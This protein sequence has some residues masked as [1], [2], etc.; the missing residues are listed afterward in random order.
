MAH[1]EFI[2]DGAAYVGVSAQARGL[3]ELKT[4][5]PARYGTLSH[6]G[7]TF[8]YDMFTQVGQNVRD[9]F[10]KVLGGLEPQRMLATGESQSAGRLVTYLNAV[11]P[12]KGVF[13]GYMVHSRGAGGA[14]LS[15]APQPAVSVP[16][17]LKI[18]NDL[19]VPVFV[20]QAEGDV[21][22]SNLGAR[23]PD[24]PLFRS[25]ELAGTS[26]A[27]S[28]TAFAGFNDRG[29]AQGAI[30]MFNLMR[31]PLAIGCA[32]PI[33]AGPHHW[34][35]QAAFHHLDEWVRTGALPPSG[36]PL[37]V[38]STSPTVLA[39]DAHGNALGGVR[40]PHVDAPIATLDAVNSGAGFCV[41]FG[42]TTPFTTTQLQ[43]LYPTHDDFVAQ[44]YA[45]LIDAVNSGFILPADAF[46][47]QAAAVVS[48]VP[49]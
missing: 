3:N 27:D 20:V 46:E 47:L 32:F 26:H 19:D 7:D 38:V 40:S 12:L 9:N 37:E 14:A 34:Q 30:Q 11:H 15:Q 45:A 29:D 36:P 2:R 8:S 10:D 33:N 17:P 31:S 39:R 49:N 42:R 35:L 22:G 24:T 25:W 16:S 13:D 41:L 1:N 4:A 48:T 21:I 6:P 23:Q 18:R 5:D 28:Y 43:A 44:W